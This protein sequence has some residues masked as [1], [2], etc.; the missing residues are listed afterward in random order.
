M[1]RR[2]DPPDWDDDDDDDD[3]PE[4]VYHD[5][6][7][8]LFVPCPY[9]REPVPEAAQ[10]CGRCE[11]YISAEDAPADRKPVWVWVCLVLALGAAVL[12]VI[13]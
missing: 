6:D 4:G 13:A 10:F 7:D 12:M 8:G 2:P 1:P 9:C 3:L 5:P 11:N